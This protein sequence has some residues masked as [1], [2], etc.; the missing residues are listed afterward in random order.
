MTGDERIFVFYLWNSWNCTFTLCIIFVTHTSQG[1]A[2]FIFFE[3]KN[4]IKNFFLLFIATLL[5]CLLL[6]HTMRF[7]WR[8]SHLEERRVSEVAEIFFLFFRKILRQHP[9]AQTV[10]RQTNVRTNVYI[11]KKGRREGK[12]K[13]IHLEENRARA[14]NIQKFTW[15]RTMSQH[16]KSLASTTKR[17]CE[18]YWFSQT[19]RIL[20]R[21]QFLVI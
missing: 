4:T 19:K 7:K 20:R 1:H 18:L 5:T 15:N 17:F 8:S 12:T 16:K 3:R 14:K 21:L 10:R 6:K 11:M 2:A 9:N 13:N